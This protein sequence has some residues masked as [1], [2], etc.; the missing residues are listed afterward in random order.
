MNVGNE[1]YVFNKLIPLL[2]LKNVESKRLLKKKKI[3]ITY[4]QF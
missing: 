3:N 4:N 1:I 2:K